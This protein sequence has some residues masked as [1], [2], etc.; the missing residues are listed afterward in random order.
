MKTAST[1]ARSRTYAGDRLDGFADLGGD[2]AQVACALNR[3]QLLPRRLGALGGCD[4]LVDGGRGRV[5]NLRDDGV[6]RRIQDRDVFRVA[7]VLEPAVDEVLVQ[8]Y[9]C[10]SRC[11]GSGMRRL[12]PAS[13][14]AWL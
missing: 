7:S 13:D 12:P 4:G 8:F 11:P 1:R 14:C 2:L 6:A 5:R 9:R 3:R 10:S